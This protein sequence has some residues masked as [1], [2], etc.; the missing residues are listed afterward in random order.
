MLPF[1]PLFIGSFVEP[2]NLITKVFTSR[3][4]Y[5]EKK[6]TPHLSCSYLLKHK[7]NKKSDVSKARCLLGGI[8]PV[9]DSSARSISFN[10]ILCDILVWSQKPQ[11]FLIYVALI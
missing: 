9:Y 6:T 10:F 1:S 11:R 4:L 7:E 8:P 2:K 3:W 5:C